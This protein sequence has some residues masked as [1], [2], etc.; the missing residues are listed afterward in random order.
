MRCPHA[1]NPAV[2]LPRGSSLPPPL[3]S[4][5][6]Y[7]L[8]L[9]K[10][11]TAVRHPRLPVAVSRNHRSSVSTGLVLSTLEILDTKEKMQSSQYQRQRLEAMTRRIGP[12]VPG[13]ASLVTQIRRFGASV[14]LPNQKYSSGNM[15]AFSSE[16]V[17]AQKANCSICQ[18]P[19]QVIHVVE[20]PCPPLTGQTPIP[21]AGWQPPKP[22]CCNGEFH[23]PPITQPPVACCQASS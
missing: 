20:C 12:R 18:N 7:T 3:R 15:T 21:V 11:S 23:G 14:R 13:V 5:R 19:A 4:Q 22:W 9:A 1:H 10:S 6:R 2:R 16:T 8:F 17:T